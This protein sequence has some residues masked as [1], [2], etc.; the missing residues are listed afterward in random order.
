MMFKKFQFNF[1]N[2]IP[3]QKLRNAWGGGQPDE[4]YLNVTLAQL[5]Y[6]PSCGGI[7]FG[8]EYTIREPHKVAEKHP[9]L[10]MFGTVQNI[11]PIF[12]RYYDGELQKIA[13]SNGHRTAYKWA[14]IAAK[15]HAN[16]RMP[17]MGRT[18]RGSIGNQPYRKETPFSFKEINQSI[19]LCTSYYETNEVRWS[20]IQKCL[21]KNLE[22]TEITKVLNLGTKVIDHPKVINLTYDR[23]TYAD[24]LKEANQLGFDYTIIA[25]SDI[26]FDHTINWVKQV[27]MNKTMFALSRWDVDNNGF[28]KLFA[29]EWS[30]DTWIFKDIPEG[31]GAYWLGLPGCDNKFAYEVHSLGFRVINPAKDI[32][33]YHLHNS[34]VRN[35][36]EADRLPPPYKEVTITTL[37]ECVK[38]S[39]LIKQPGK[40]GDIINCLPIAKFYSKEYLVFWECPKEYHR[41]FAYVDYVTPVESGKADKVIDLSFGLNR[42]SPTNAEWN[43]V[44]NHESFAALKYRLAN[45][46]VSELRNLEYKRNIPAEISLFDILNPKEPYALV[47]DSSDYGTK[48]EIDTRLK[49]VKFERQ[50]GY[51]IFDW[52]K[53]IEGASEIHCIDSSLCNFVD[54]LDVKAELFYYKT[55][56]VPLKGDETVLTKNWNRLEYANS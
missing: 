28:S 49:I 50:N 46:P 29:Y 52:R 8:N 31:I 6:D 32:R 7:Y 33:T 17:N 13:R 1:M 45:V 44:R 48:P 54:C 3:L 22:N 35:Y 30:Q 34:N 41:L 10:S 20:E 11:K 21:D 16:K 56:R 43:K 51:E 38:K 15:K 24:F 37:G 5:G 39:L 55:D 2:P 27:N 23:P 26:Y 12:V 19:L 47:H 53:V 42:Q 25:N 18:R 14:N 36:G 40:V 9:I 4:L